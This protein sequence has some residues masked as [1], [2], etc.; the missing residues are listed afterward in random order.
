[1]GKMRPIMVKGHTRPLTMLKYNREGDLL[2]STGKDHTPSVWYSDNGE[3]IGT[4][5][6]HCGTVWCLDVNCALRLS[7]A[8]PLLRVTIPRGPVPPRLPSL[9]PARWRA[10]CSPTLVCAP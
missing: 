6:G 4:Y 9:P 8:A 7:P 1:M 2:F 10:A 3:R 5:D